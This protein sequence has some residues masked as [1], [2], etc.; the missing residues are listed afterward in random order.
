MDQVTVTPHH[1]HP[2]TTPTTICCCIGSFF[3]GHSCP[4]RPVRVL[5][6]LIAVTLCFSAT[7]SYSEQEVS[8]ICESLFNEG[9]QT[10][11]TEQLTHFLW[12]LPDHLKCLESALKAHA[13]VLFSQQQWKQLYRLLET[14]KFSPH[15]HQVLQDLWLRAHYTEAEKTKERELGAVC[16]YRIRKKNPFPS[17]IWDGEETNY[18]FKSKSRNVLRDAYKKQ[19]Y[20]SVEEKKRLAAQTE[21]T[22][23]QVSNWFKNKRQRERAA[24]TLE[25]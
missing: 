17:T 4:N 1:Q 24:G 23:T 6:L 21:L 22:V 3:F 12:T 13:L 9:L 16:K 19:A 14:H 20:P 11:R 15:N 8:C 7:T 5:L 25:K 18:C 10:G 2:T